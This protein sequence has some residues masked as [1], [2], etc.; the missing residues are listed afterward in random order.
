MKRSELEH[1]IRAAGAIADDHEIVILGSQSILGQFPD[2]P[3]ALLTSMEA[4][5]FPLNRPELADLIDGSIGEG[6]AFHELY[7]YYAQGV[8]A[9]VAVLPRGWQKRLVKV[10]NPN[11][12]GI[13][14][15]CLD[16]HDLA[17]SKYV[18][19]R[20]KDLQFT[21]ELARHRFT[22]PA[23]LQARLELTAVP[24]AIGTFIK[25]RIARDFP[26]VRF[27]RAR[28]RYKAA[29]RRPAQRK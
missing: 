25:A 19:G 12:R 9:R 16:V 13:A 26:E 5:V 2:A 21:R 7:G 11:T 8:D 18:A 24:D 4:D 20:E 15:L 17:I 10:L 23:T 29:A 6:S 14:G 3:A 22:D 1:V 28:K 27:P